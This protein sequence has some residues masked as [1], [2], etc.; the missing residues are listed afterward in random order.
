MKKLFII[1]SVF[2]GLFLLFSD[3][4]YSQEKDFYKKNWKKVDSLMDKDLPRSSLKTIDIIYKKATEENNQDQIL[5][6]YVFYFKTNNYKE[7]Y[8]DSLVYK[9]ENDLEKAPMPNKS[10][11]H[12]M[13]GELYWQYFKANM[14]Q[15]NNRTQLADVVP[16]DIQTWT[17][18]NFVE[19][20][21]YHYNSSLKDE[22]FLQ[23][24]PAS[25]YTEMINKGTKEKDLRP[26]LFDFL[27]ARAIKFYSSTEANITRPLDYFQIM[28]S[29]FYLPAN[30]FV[31]IEIKSPDTLSLHYNAIKIFQKWLKFR[32]KNKDE[33]NALIDAELNRINFINAYSVNPQKEKLYIKFLEH[34]ASQYPK[35][36]QTA[37]TK[38][39]IADFYYNNAS[40]YSPDDKSTQKYKDFYIKAE[41]LYSQIIKEF[42]TVK[43]VSKRAQGKI[44]SI[45]DKYLSLYVQQVY[46]PS[47]P[48]AVKVLY[49]NLDKIN[50]ELR[51]INYSDYQ[52]LERN[53]ST[54]DFI[55][56]IRNKYDLAANSSFKIRNL[57]DF[58]KHSTEIL[59]DGLPTGGYVILVSS[60]NSFKD[61]VDVSYSFFQVSNLSFVKQELE[62]G[63]IEGYVLNRKTGEPMPDVKIK[64]YYQKYS[65]VL[66]RYVQKRYG[67]YTSDKKGKV[68]I[69][70]KN[71]EW[72]SVYFHLQ[73]GYDSLM[74]RS[75]VYIY[76]KKP[77]EKSTPSI[78]IFT[79]RKLY[80]PGQTVYFKGI[81]M[82]NA[83]KEKRKI[84][85]KRSVTV[86]F[87]D[88]NSQKISS[89]DFITN[90]F[91]TF[92]GSFQIPV[93]LLNG[94]MRLQSSYGSV[95]IQVEEYKR[96]AFFVELETPDKQ[97]LVNDTVT[98]SGFAENYSGVKISDAKVQYKIVRKNLWF[99]WW[100]WNYSQDEIL[101]A[102]GVSETDNNG[103]FKIDFLATPD[104]SMPQKAQTA[105]SYQIDVNVTDMNGETHSSN[106]VVNVGYTALKV[107]LSLSDKISKE[108]LKTSKKD[109]VYINSANLN[110]KEVESAGV[111]ELYRLEQPK[112]VLRSRYWK[113]PDE[114]I[115]TKS[116]WYDKFP[117][118]E[119]KDEAD[120]RFWKEDKKVW[121]K[122][123]NTAASKHIDISDFEDFKSG[124]YKIIVKTKDDF[125]NDVKK[126][127]FFTLFS[128]KSK[129]LPYQTSDWFVPLKT[130]CSPGENAKFIIGSGGITKVIYQIER[131]DEILKQEIIDI[132][133]NQKYIEIPITEDM[134]GGF[135]VS[136]IFTLNNRVYSHSSTIYVPY[137][138][139]KLEFEFATFRDKLKPG[140]EEEWK[141]IIK[142]KDGDFALA[143]LMTTLYDA[144]L[145]DIMGFNWYFNPFTYY[146]GS[147]NWSYSTFDKKSSYN[148]SSYSLPY[149]S[150]PSSVYKSLNWFS[151]YYYHYYGYNYQRYRDGDD[152]VYAEE[153]EVGLGGKV[154]RKEKKGVTGSVVDKTSA[155]NDREVNQTKNLEQPK[156]S[157]DVQIRKN[158]NETAFFYPQL[159]TNKNGEVVISFTIPESLTEW[160][161]LGLAH[162]KDLKYGLYD[163][164]VITQKELMV[165]PNAP[166]FFRQKDT[167]Y[168]AAK[169]ANLSEK[170]ISGTVSI[171]FIDETTGKT[172]DIFADGEKSSKKFEVKKDLSTPVKWKI[173]IPDD[174]ELISYKII[175]KSDK[176]SDGEQ[177]ALPVMSNR[178]LVTEALPLPIRAN[179]TKTFKFEKLIN[180]A[181]STSIKNEK[182]TV[183][184]TS[185][186]AWY[187]VQALPYLI[188][189]PYECSE[190]IF[191]RYYANTLASYI[192]NSS[193]KIKKVFDR[194]RNYEPSA[195]M[196]N[197]EKNQ[198]L[199]QVLLEETPWVLEAQDENE[200]KHRIALL[201]DMN[202]MANEKKT[203]LRKLKKEQSINGGWA[204]FKGMPESWY[205]TQYIA[206]GFG[207]LKKLNIIENK[208]VTVMNMAEKAVKFTDGEMKDAYDWLKR[209]FTKSQMQEHR[210]GQIIIHYF[211]TRSF[212]DYQ[213]PAKYQKASNYYYAQLK[214]YWTDY[215][216]HSK[217]LLALAFYRN[218]DVD[219][220]NDI[221]KSLSENALY[222]QELGMYWKENVS[223]YYWY[224]APIETQSLMIEVYNEVAK[225]KKKVDELKIWLLKNK[226]TNDWKTTT[227]TAKAI[228]ALLLTGGK[229]LL[230]NSKI[231]P[232]ILGDVTIDPENN[233]DIKTEAGTGYYKVSFD[234]DEVKPKMGNIKVE[235]KNDI[236]A[237]GAVYWQYWEDL[238]KITPHE[239]PLKLKKDLYKKVTSDYGDKLVLIDK[240]TKLKVG[241]KVIVRIELRVDRKMEYV[242]MKDM[243]AAAFEPIN[244]ISSYKWQDGLGYYETTKD[245]STNFFFDYLPKGTYV[246]EYPVVVSSEGSYS[247]GITTIQCMYAPE[248]MSHSKGQRVYI[249]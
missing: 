112:N 80:R 209:N 170:D 114:P 64:A 220:A 82:N 237:W 116:Q 70:P 117:G 182:L 51:K 191:A 124:V 100:F 227:A 68:L 33:K 236:V 235:N 137:D 163:K 17:A 56:K 186:P 93:G 5:K 107:S 134:R 123:Y 160:R 219:I 133:D 55:P 31:N 177:K 171:E 2:F 63:S 166:R 119:Y 22:Q 155:V 8:F 162:T 11:M 249:K 106:S 239:T 244:V 102:H 218:G 240:N 183:E 28:D 53:N 75:S 49:R 193:P 30:K 58:Q 153:S 243:R 60:K 225:D 217:G 139:K 46:L 50:V 222:H 246:F 92:H 1:L 147:Y 179:K 98:V 241:D 185:N 35:T 105:F 91:G 228:Y 151:Y 201:F 81:M 120:F 195:L 130:T 61:S 165:M 128:E 224:Q 83:S 111:I 14:W 13:L 221:V 118:N 36:R 9:M 43:V 32:L 52:K 76:D 97:Y 156:G 99:G 173:I 47:K 42:D 144:S 20:S 229:D 18:E 125:G 21:I 62:N 148:W 67:T 174:G 88:V 101:I 192:A 126:E 89:R 202:R 71:S 41:K 168:F 159:K 54:E 176:F 115:Y 247:N 204:W 39:A 199:K 142:D 129:K 78:S 12:S 242:H 203:A 154:K 143:E 172:I 135:G 66:K 45:N 238:D 23:K 136:F 200:R 187:A 10:M 77:Y 232:V 24:T 96:P 104:L 6:C 65:Y 178:M 73:T 157:G 131:K 149:V 216:L 140:D 16:E 198:E 85:P 161:F 169:V 48:F 208:D 127:Q 158:F 231:C 138:N 40:K 69:E 188:E 110:N 145:D 25:Y 180:S 109:S 197:L 90:E 94:S 7:N 213:L 38:L 207:H 189:Y 194:W 44:Y 74:D 206:E 87:Y 79:D 86:T 26:T 57:G 108:Q 34:L 248:F 212:F 223:G 152:V 226:Q 59:L 27:A 3:K 184:F 146:Y 196:S 210:P 233:P 103:K 175:A 132:D 205:I 29:Y 164:S 84:L 167:M 19:K 121:T 190:Q 234:G 15:I 95:Y 37:Y 211:Y 150:I 72:T 245:A 181:S 4:A 215:S 230:A 122:K 214:K 141:I 113:K